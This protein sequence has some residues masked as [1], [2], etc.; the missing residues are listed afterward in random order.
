[1]K[2]SV[3]VQT[4]DGSVANKRDCRFIKGDFYIKNKQCFLIN[5]T[6]YRVNS[7]F[8]TYDNE[9]RQWVIIK[10]NP[11][12]IKGIVS[13]DG[14]EAILGF[15]TQNKFKN[16][17][18][19]L[20]DGRI[21]SCID[22]KILPPGYFRENVTEMVFEHVSYKT[23]R[24]SLGLTPTRSRLAKSFDE[25]F[26][27]VDFNNHGYP[28]TLPYCTKHYDASMYEKFLKSMVVP[29]SFSTNIGRYYHELGNL[30]FGFEFETNFGKIPNYRILE[31]GLIP[32]R[33]GS[34]SGIE[35]AT[36]PLSGRTGILALENITSLL[37]KYVSISENE[38][39]HLHIGNTTTTKKYI[40]YL[41]TLC[42]VLEKE[43][44]SLF[45]QYYAQTSKFKARGKDY[46]MPL[47][48]ELVTDD[49][50]ET[51]SN[52]AFYLSDGKKYQGFGSN[53]PSDP[54]G[55]HKWQVN[56]RYH[57]CNFIPL[58][59]GS[60][61]TIEFRVHI[62]TRNTIKVLNWLYICSAIVKYA[63][64]EHKKDNALSNVKY[65]TLKDI[66]NAVYTPKL[67]NYLYEYISFRKSERK[68]NDV[69]G[70]F[71]GRTE[72]MEEMTGSKPF[73]HDIN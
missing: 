25:R 29:N 37:T 72:I 13:F 18:V 22:Y 60:N 35:F 42:C 2:N 33:D 62:P 69:A 66:F 47:R 65:V 58:M 20:K 27:K 26:P 19:Y 51:F 31:S 64:L 24:E 41:Y 73:F 21:L 50:D 23:T 71:T 30:S 43:I 36:I 10:D 34:I 4:F 59:F 15:Y 28:I 32:L 1:M 12:L 56:S 54:D 16:V 11:N 14:E 5:D 38:S 57:W 52:I 17:T 8:I 53:H 49:C 67:A 63:E 3:T 55:S 70:D 6:W 45:P 40:S 46:N 61:N 39:L 48:K 7:G 68:L 44:F 9:T